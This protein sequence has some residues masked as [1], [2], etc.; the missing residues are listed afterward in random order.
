[1]KI[2]LFFITLC[3]T[4]VV[5]A[6]SFGTT[7]A[8]S[9]S[10]QANI[11]TTAGP[12]QMFFSTLD[13]TESDP[14]S[15]AQARKEPLATPVTVRG[16]ITGIATHESESQVEIFV[17]DETAG[18]RVM[19]TSD[20]VAQVFGDDGFTR[21][22]VLQLTGPRTEV[23][24]DQ[25][26]DA[27]EAFLAE[28]PF[29]DL[30]P[31]HIFDDLTDWN[32]ESPY[33]GSPVILR[34]VSLVKPEQWPVVATGGD[35]VV[36][37][38]AGN[39]DLFQ[40]RIPANTALNPSARPP[41]QFSVAGVMANDGGK[42]Q[43]VIGFLED[44]IT[45]T[46]TGV[47]MF[48]L[49]EGFR[50]VTF[51]VDVSKLSGGIFL[52]E[53][54]DELRVAYDFHVWNE[55]WGMSREGDESSTYTFTG[56]VGGMAGNVVEYKYLIIPGDGR[57]LPNGGWEALADPMTGETG[58]TGNRVLTLG[59]RGEPMTTN[60][61]ASFRADDTTAE[62]IPLPIQ[63]FSSTTTVMPGET[64]DVYVVVG[65]PEN[66]GEGLFG[67]GLG[68]SYFD[69]ELACFCFQD[70][71]RVKMFDGINLDNL[72][73]FVDTST[74]PGQ[75]FVSYALN[76]KT[77]S[78]P[79]FGELLRIE[80][81]V[82]PE[83]PSGQ[84]FIKTFNERAVDQNGTPFAVTG[85]TLQI[86]V[87]D[88]GLYPGDTNRDGI[89]D[90]FDV[91]PLSKWFLRE[92]P[93]RPNPSMEWAPQDF[94]A[95]VDQ[96]ATFADADGN[97]IVDQNDLFPIGLNFG[98]TTPEYKAPEPVVSK[99]AAMTAPVAF[100]LPAMQPGDVVR[101]QVELGTDNYP[102]TEVR[103][104]AMNLGFD[105]ASLSLTSAEAGSWTADANLLQ[106][107]RYDVDRGLQSLSLARTDGA[108]MVE[109]S[110]VMLTF[111]AQD[112]IAEGTAVTL[113][114]A[115]ITHNDGVYF[116]P[117]M[118][119]SEVEVTSTGWT[120]LPTQLELSQNYPNPFNPTTQIS[121]SLPQEQQVTL[122][123]YTVMGQRVATLASGRMAPGAH[124]V[125][126]NAAGLS[127]GM[128]VY[129]LTTETGSLSRTMMLIK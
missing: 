79:S 62:G 112:A 126:F 31:V 110:A 42:P 102:I 90:A 81:T 13:T 64:F 83:M 82:H 94:V 80:F 91:D 17:S 85:S 125:T 61:I 43:V 2:V 95:W 121:F 123:V 40:V 44:K 5:A 63:L 21:G 54:G 93:A 29:E 53:L 101:Y 38:A 73:G 33:M 49:R 22:T 78:F 15:I 86:N 19:M 111:E 27:V 8:G 48:R 88:N 128:Y 37:V 69:N 12:H 65:S 20:L 108:A 52:P 11:Q 26:I 118:R 36:D 129:R 14:V 72:L 47:E 10:D 104:L 57:D 3:M 97:G 98:L 56:V 124:A 66:P 28:A 70:L 41:V 39:G 35:A 9:A 74:I 119:F 109:G 107:N 100:T 4:H 24:G 7:A 30:N 71:H 115:Q 67:V 96:P 46:V 116:W 34:S 51:T 1:M 68:L 23:N 103:S 127:S 18:I 87:L 122:E 25:R 84:Y 76:D 59:T 50:D 92:G 89:V 117:R 6:A 114:A 55:T 75:L 77:M 99:L 106:L 58:T 60:D 45:S 120:E 32:V 105:A 16:M 113:E